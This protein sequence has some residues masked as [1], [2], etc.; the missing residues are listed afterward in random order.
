MNKNGGLQR[1]R[2]FRRLLIIIFGISFLAPVH[3]E[4]TIVRKL[5]ESGEHKAEAEWKESGDIS[6][7]KAAG[8][9]PDLTPEISGRLI[10]GGY[11]TGSE[12]AVSI[13]DWATDSQINFSSYVGQAGIFEAKAQAF[14]EDSID[15]F[16]QKYNGSLNYATPQLNMQLSGGYDEKKLIKAEGETFKSDAALAFQID[17]SEESR[18]PT[19]LRYKSNWRESEKELES[20][21]QEVVNKET[22]LI[23]F[24]TAMQLG[25]SVLD[26][27]SKANIKR[28]PGD[29][30]TNQGY[31]GTLGLTIPITGL[32][33]FIGSSSPSYSFT[34]YEMTDERS[35]ERAID[36][37]MGLLFIQEELFEAVIKAGR[38]DAWQSDPQLT[39][40]TL[41][42]S[43]LWLGNSSFNL[44]YPEKLTSEAGYEI[45]RAP[46]G[47]LGHD[48]SAG[49]TWKQDEGLLRE[50]GAHGQFLFKEYETT[51][52]EQDGSD[53]NNNG[54]NLEKEK[55]GANLL[56]APSDASRLSAGYKGYRKDIEATTWEH[57][58]HSNFTH[59]PIE[60]F[61]YNLAGSYVYNSKDEEETK[62]Y[63]GSGGINLQPVIQY[64][65][66]TIGATETFELEDTAEGKDKL[67]K[68]TTSL[69]VPFSRQMRMQYGFT[70]EWVDF[71]LEEAEEGFA[72]L[73]ATGF[74]LSGAPLP[75]M[76]KTDYLI[77]H[78]FRGVQ[79]QVNAAL[80]IPMFESWNL[81]SKISYR[82]A[83]AVTYETP[84]IFST[85]LHYEF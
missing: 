26:V 58:G 40:D 27:E 44:T 56:I 80:E 85:L 45:S 4:V 25:E 65:R 68:T 12:D 22:H 30:I 31:N 72:F 75:F 5:P 61:S 64:T 79:H 84:F 24:T 6:P 67:S 10:F 71:Y 60:G 3:T 8:R 63:S 20:E 69:A 23:T 74:S 42:H 37:R 52:T 38:I 16:D 2:N 62:T 9:V 39:S 7:E 13:D 46:E 81:I 34:D 32:I 14:R 66:L 36:N 47:A 21:D 15:R 77:G 76:L 83:E 18:F 50:A 57:S 43:T 73:H 17:T 35:E 51:A 19:S 41:S 54:S 48:L 28:N 1:V 11:G 55:W 82:Y 29:E 53:G 70:L 33:S 78:G 59:S 49:T